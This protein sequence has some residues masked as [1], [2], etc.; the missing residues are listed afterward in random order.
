M[1]VIK[2]SA[3]KYKKVCEDFPNITI[4]TKSSTPGVVESTFGH[5]T[6]GNKSLGESAVAFDLV[7]DL[8]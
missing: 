5:V 8:I 2:L 4:L 6:V 3:K 1:C 7:V